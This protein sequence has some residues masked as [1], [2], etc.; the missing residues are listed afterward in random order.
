MIRN[1]FIDHYRYKKI[2]A[3]DLFSLSNKN[4]A[5]EMMEKIRESYENCSEVHIKET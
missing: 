2:D 5:M 3:R 4:E 1:G